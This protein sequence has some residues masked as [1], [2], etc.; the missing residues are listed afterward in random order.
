[1]CKEMEF[2]ALDKDGNEVLCEVL[3]TFT[4]EATGKDY[5]VYT[6]HSLDE[7]GNTKVYASIYDP[8]DPESNLLPVESDLEWYYIQQILEEIQ[9]EYAM[10]M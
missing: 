3:F 8:S 10:L 4:G 6:D 1:M 5:I 9:A 2:K 7:E